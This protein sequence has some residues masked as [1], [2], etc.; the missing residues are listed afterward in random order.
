MCGYTTVIIKSENCDTLQ[1]DYINDRRINVMLDVAHG[2]VPL[3]IQT[4]LS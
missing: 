1:S 2:C 3:D 4:Y